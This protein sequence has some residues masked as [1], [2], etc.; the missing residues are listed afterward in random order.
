VT[1]LFPTDSLEVL[2]FDGSAQLFP[3]FFNTSTAQE[4]FSALINEV[5]WEEHQLVLF[6]KK[7]SEPRRSAWIA[8]NDIHYVY[9]GVERPAHIWTPTLTSIREAITRGTGQRFNSV[10][11]NLYRDGNDAM[12]W[13]SDDEPC[14]GPEPVIASV[15]FGAERRFDFRHRTSKEKASVVLPHGSLL[16]MSGLSQHCWQHSIARSKKVT[17]PRINLTFRFVTSST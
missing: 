9:S 15:S 5:P 17:S 7:V 13:H 10:L 1:S 16:L 6:G 2:P 8:D 4:H 3:Q 14:N 12:G 11:A